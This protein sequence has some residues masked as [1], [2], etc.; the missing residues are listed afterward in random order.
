M[1]AEEIVT[2]IRETIGNI[3]SLPYTYV[4]DLGELENELFTL[5]WLYAHAT[6]RI[7]D[8]VAAV[9]NEPREQFLQFLALKQS[10]EAIGASDGTQQI[11]DRW[12]ARGQLIGLTM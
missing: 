4:G 9:R 11:I 6:E 3:Y 8:F 2:L 1:T 7:D 12:K 5:H 10:H